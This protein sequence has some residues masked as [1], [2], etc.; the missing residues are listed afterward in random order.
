MDS[1]E[2]REWFSGLTEAQKQVFLALVSSELTLDGRH[3]GSISGQQQIRGF[4]GLNE[5]QHYISGH[6]A[7]LG[8]GR[9]RHTHT[10]DFLWKILEEK[11]ALYGLKSSLSNALEFAR[12][13]DLWNK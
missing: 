6:I 3:L 10:D 11:A 13:R 12:T 5:M 1:I 4:V 8:P 7:G 2:I 9:D